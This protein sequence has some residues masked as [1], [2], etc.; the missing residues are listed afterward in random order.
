MRR[1]VV[2]LTVQKFKPF[3]GYINQ[4][5]SEMASGQEIISGSLFLILN[6]FNEKFIEG[7]V[8]AQNTVWPNRRDLTSAG[9]KLLC[10]FKMNQ[11]VYESY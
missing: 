10:S 5:F 7:C 2:D 8:P 4:S 6:A 9:T 3:R 11:F 1:S